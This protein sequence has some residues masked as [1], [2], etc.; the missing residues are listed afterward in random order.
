MPV[1]PLFRRC[2]QPAIDVA[3]EGSRRPARP[4][5]WQQGRRQQGI[6]QHDPA[7]M[8]DQE[9][10]CDE[11]IGISQPFAAADPSATVTRYVTGFAPALTKSCT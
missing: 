9:N 3:A 1:K 2:K 11:G 8:V 6:A 10:A 5:P 7:V 4:I